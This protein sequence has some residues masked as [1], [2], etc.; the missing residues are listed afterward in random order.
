MILA[1]T[2][3]TTGP[4][5][6]LTR[7]EIPKVAQPEWCRNEIDHFVLAQIETS[8]ITPSPEAEKATLARRLFIDVTGLP[9]TIEEIDTYM[10]DTAPGAYERLVDHLFTTEPYRTRYAERMATPW[11]D[12]ARYADTSGI[13]MD[14]GRSIWPWRDWVLE[15]YRDNMPFDRFVIEQLSGDQL[16]D[17]TYEQIIASGFNRNHVTSDE[18]G[19]INDEY[20]LEYAVD[21]TNTVGTVFLGLSVGCARCHDHKFDPVSTEEFYSL[22][23]F[24]NNNEEPGVYSQIQDP[25]RALEPAFELRQDEDR[26]HITELQT[27]LASL[28]KQRN[29]P[30]PEEAGQ[31]KTFITDLHTQGGWAW[32]QAKIDS[33]LSKGGATMSVQPDGSVLASGENPATDEY[34]LTLTTDETNLRT[35]LIEI[36]PDPS[37]ANNR[38]GRPNNGNAIMSGVTAEVVSKIGSVAEATTR[39]HLGMGGL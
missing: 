18:G 14:A 25:Y 4:F 30:S 8:E 27:M 10:A 28:K 19:A 33:A 7:P 3:K 38:V 29:T 16:P 1:P 35:V 12:L 31:I 22:L 37:Q 9:P 39:L 36:M 15:A 6:Q 5:T 34:T 24:F 23:A 21:R 26:E 20:L 11:L 2:T 17:A 13:H 32:H